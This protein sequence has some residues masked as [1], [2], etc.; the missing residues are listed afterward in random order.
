MKR[1]KKLCLT[2]T[3]TSC[4]GKKYIILDRVGLLLRLDLGSSEVE[5]SEYSLSDEL[6][7]IE[8]IYPAL[9]FQGTMELFEFINFLRV[10]ELFVTID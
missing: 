9:P 2:C 10:S 5:R 4:T 7:N 8:L 1:S 3:R 6:L